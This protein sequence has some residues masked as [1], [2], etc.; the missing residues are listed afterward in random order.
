MSNKTEVLVELICVCGCHK[1]MYGNL[2]IQDDPNTEITELVRTSLAD[3]GWT[4]LR[5]SG[6]SFLGV[7]PRCSKQDHSI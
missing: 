2:E 5:G 7:S 4:E 6:L 3:I 1:F